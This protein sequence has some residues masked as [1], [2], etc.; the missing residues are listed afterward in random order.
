MALA[1]GAIA[2]RLTYIQ[3]VS[4]GRYAAMGRSQRIR[5]VTLNGERGTI[6][7]RNGQPLALSVDQTSFWANPH[8]VSDPRVEAEALAPMLGL[9]AADLQG[10]LSSDASFV[11]LARKVDDDTAARVKALH[12]DGVFD[13]QEPKRFDPSGDLAAPLL[14]LVGTDNTGLSGLEQKYD[15]TLSGHPGK[16][17]AESDPR[18]SPIPGGLRQYSPPTRGQDLVLTIDESLQYQTEQALA[19]EIV[20]ARARAGMALMMDSRSGELLAVAN[21]VT[22]PPPA[23]TDPSA[24]PAPWPQPVPAPS[25]TTFTNVYEPGSVNKLITVSAALQE[26]TVRPAE[27]FSI[28]NTIQVGDTTFHEAE[29][30]PVENWSVTDI[31]ANSSNVGAITIGEKLGKD[32][33]D[34][35]LRAFGFGQHTD[36]RFPGES[37]GLVLDPA[38]WYSTSIGT[39]PIGQGISVT[40]I[41]MLAAY[42]TIANGGVYVGPKLVKAT[43]DAKGRSHGTPPSVRRRVVSAP[44][45]ADM[46]TMLDEVVR[47]GTG[48]AAQIDGYTVAGK[49]GTARK[50]AP[51]GRGYLSG[52]YMSSFAGFVPAE[53]PALTGIVI[54]DEPTPIFGGLVAAPVFASAARYGLREFRILPELAVPPPPGVPLA[55][56]MTAKAAGEA[57]APPGLA[58]PVVAPSQPATTTLP[59]TT[60]PGTAPAT[61]PPAAPVP[62]GQPPSPSSSTVST[63]TSSTTTPRQSGP[64]PTTTAPANRPRTP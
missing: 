19:S 1:F 44:V 9:T 3:A 55:T 47:V 10:K 34:H 49:T 56:P 32:R 41:Q 64:A 16:M 54:L 50:V 51:G 40:A 63:T 27:R 30:H 17:I 24:P 20:A 7:D 38:H 8:L 42:N 46:T 33:L 6:F 11:Y 12:L 2:V 48:T 28:A 58:P 35:Y 37:P 23:S 14:G 59:G 62:A 4:G 61:A 57:A 45:A 52:A 31:V 21:L 36:L 39:V 22:P 29:D 26:G 18:G 53:K 60:N 13:I 43:L 15:T 25:A 5:S